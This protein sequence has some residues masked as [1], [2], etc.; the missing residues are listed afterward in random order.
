MSLGNVPARGQKMG[1]HQGQELVIA[2]YA[3]AKELLM[4]SSSGTTKET[5]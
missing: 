4:L 1:V 2:G 5:G 3:L